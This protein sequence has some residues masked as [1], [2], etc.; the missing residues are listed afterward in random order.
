MFLAASELVKLLKPQ[1]SLPAITYTLLTNK[2]AKILWRLSRYNLFSN[3]CF[4]R[5]NFFFS[6]LAKNARYELTFSIVHHRFVSLSL[7]RIIFSFCRRTNLTIPSS[8]AMFGMRAYLQ[9]ASSSLSDPEMHK[10]PVRNLLTSFSK[11]HWGKKVA[12]HH[13]L[14]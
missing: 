3:W 7:P 14:D 9:P 12:S 11:S 6:T 10:F 13:I 5:S 2:K 8:S 4:L 1:K